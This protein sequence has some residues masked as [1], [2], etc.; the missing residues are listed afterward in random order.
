MQ[1]QIENDKL[2]LEGRKKLN[3]TGVET[4]NSFSETSLKLT[5]GGKTVL[6]LGENIR[7]DSYNKA[8][9]SLSATGIF[10]EIKYSYKK[11]PLVK[12]IFR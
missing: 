5:V 4:V 8:S 9:G 12:K 3:M 2:N 11:Q 6:I 1:N 7:I 10:N